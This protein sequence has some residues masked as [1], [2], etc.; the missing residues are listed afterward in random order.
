M[1]WRAKNLYNS[2]SWLC[3]WSRNDPYLK[4]FKIRSDNSLILAGK[5]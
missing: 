3:F 4:F 1:K 5:T 2:N